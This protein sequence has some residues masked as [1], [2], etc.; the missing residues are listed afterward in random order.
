MVL[1]HAGSVQN[2]R[3]NITYTTGGKGEHAANRPGPCMVGFWSRRLPCRCRGSPLPPLASTEKRRALSEASCLH[4]SPGIIYSVRP[5][6]PP[7]QELRGLKAEVLQVSRCS[8]HT[9]G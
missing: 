6:K 8:T 2:M 3:R 1:L 4:C 9:Q 7:A 5:W